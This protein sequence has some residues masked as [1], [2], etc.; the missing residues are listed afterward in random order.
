[1]SLLQTNAP[2][3]KL[4]LPTLSG[5]TFTLSKN[6]PAN[7][8]IVVFY[9]GLH[10]PICINYLQEIEENLEALAQAGMDIVAISMDSEV[11]A[12]ATQS[13][14]ASKMGIDQLKTRI[15]YGL[16]EDDARSWGLYI[17]SKREDS[18]E[19]ETFC[20][21]GLFVIRPDNSVY[22]AQVQSAPFTRPNIAKMIG[23]LQYAVE[24]KYPARGTRTFTNTRP[25][26]SLQ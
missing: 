20:E 3:P 15:A 19:P 12:Q 22:M 21:P 16:T 24:H 7:F 4:T 25:P 17:S 23:G 6:D 14:V 1:M 18:S 9:R 5:E 26:A 13:K 10:C 2:A 11:K 8:T